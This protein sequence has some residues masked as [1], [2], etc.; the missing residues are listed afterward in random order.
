MDEPQEKK[1]F[2]DQVL[3]DDTGQ[4]E[5]IRRKLSSG[6][7]VTVVFGIELTPVEAIEVAE[8]LSEVHE[9]LGQGILEE[10]WDLV[11]IPLHTGRDAA[12]AL[13]INPTSEEINE[14]RGDLLVLS[15]AGVI[16]DA[17]RDDPS[18]DGQPTLDPKLN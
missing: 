5:V 2:A 9:G 13:P 12:L 4:C 8:F 6:R 11:P 10:V 16:E 14:L 1:M 17:L 3:P 7:H 18:V 15:G